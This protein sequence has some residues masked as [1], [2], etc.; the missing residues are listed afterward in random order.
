MRKMDNYKLLIKK[1]ITGDLSDLEKTNLTDWDYVQVR[2]FEWLNDYWNSKQLDE[3]QMEQ[4]TVDL[5]YSLI[6][7]LQLPIAADPLN[8]TQSLFFKT[9]YQTPERRKQDLLIEST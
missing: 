2:D 4:D 6:D 9:V 1:Y 3:D 8:G 7:E 5:G